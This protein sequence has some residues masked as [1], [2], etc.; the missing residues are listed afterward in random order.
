VR[1][2]GLPSPSQHVKC[3]S[4]GSS[5]STSI[6]DPSSS[7]FISLQFLYFH[8]TSSWSK[9]MAKLIPHSTHLSRTSSATT[10]VDSAGPPPADAPP[11][12]PPGALDG[13]LSAPANDGDDNDD[14]GA[15]ARPPQ[16]PCAIVGVP[17]ALLHPVH[18]L[19]ELAQPEQGIQVP[20]SSSWVANHLSLAEHTNGSPTSYIW[21][22]LVLLRFFTPS[23]MKFSFLTSK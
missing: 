17:A 2:L 21:E 22:I 14:G 6:V 5:S 4:T 13:G 8:S 9:N 18:R 1:N 20:C 7:T 11:V 23:V 3:T 19:L 16:G 10:V 12:A 15:P